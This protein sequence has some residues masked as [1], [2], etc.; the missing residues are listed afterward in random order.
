MDDQRPSR[1]SGVIVAAIL[2]LSLI[3][4]YFG[5]YF[6]LSSRHPIALTS[7]KTLEARVFQAEWEMSFFRPACI[8]E[9]LIIGHKFVAT[10]GPD[11]H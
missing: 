9:S 1:A 3:A 8:V 7:G 4:A 11:W 5:A 10:S 6:G 2:V